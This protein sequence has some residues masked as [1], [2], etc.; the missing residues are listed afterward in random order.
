[1]IELFKLGGFPMFFIVAFGLIA[2]VTA[3][4]YAVRP[5]AEHEGFIRLM[6][7]ATLFSVFSGTCADFAAVCRHVARHADEMNGKQMAAIVV[8]GFGESM[9]PGIFGF[10]LLSLVAIMFAVGKRRRDARG[11]G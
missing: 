8:E 3:F 6:S 4:V 10:T 11:G 7:V 5:R 9:S 2:L 1:M